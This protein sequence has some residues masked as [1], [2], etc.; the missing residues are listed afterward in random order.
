MLIA[1][2]VAACARDSR[3]PIGAANIRVF[4]ALPGQSTSV[5]YLDM[6][7]DSRTPVT[8][9]RVSSPEFARAEVHKTTISDGIVKMQSLHSVKIE[10]T[11]QL[12]FAPGGLHIMLIGPKRALL[13][14][15][16]VQ[17]EFAMDD[18]SI[19]VVDAPVLNRMGNEQ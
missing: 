5:A 7:N 12:G 19:V 17:L 14:G 3:P 6:R 9:V 10:A 4:A 11:S 8:I 18:G 15:A 2:L 16:S 1:I 13:P